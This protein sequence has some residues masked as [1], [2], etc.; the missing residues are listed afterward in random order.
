MISFLIGHVRI[1]G[2]GDYL[3]TR[4]AHDPWHRCIFE[5]EHGVY[6]TRVERNGKELRTRRVKLPKQRPFLYAIGVE[7]MLGRKYR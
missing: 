1:I 7:I 2:M 6:K 5:M 3:G 4:R